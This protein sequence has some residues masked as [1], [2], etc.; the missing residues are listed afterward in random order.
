MALTE[1]GTGY[2]EF[3]GQY[4]IPGGAITGDVTVTVSSTDTYKVT[5]VAGPNG[6]VTGT[7]TYVVDK[8]SKLSSV[9]ANLNNITKTGNTAY[10]F[11]AWQIGRAHV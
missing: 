4:T 7:T 3:D 11:K 9:V 10:E 6:T 2:H 5:F 1:A 8:D